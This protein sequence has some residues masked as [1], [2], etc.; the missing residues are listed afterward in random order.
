[1]TDVQL[2]LADKLRAAPCVIAAGVVAALHVGK[3]PPALPVL[4]QMLGISLLQASFLLSLVQ[5]AGMTLGLLTG[6][7]VQ[8]LGLTRS[9]TAG[10]LLLGCAS[11]LGGLADSAAWFAGALNGVALRIIPFFTKLAGRWQSGYVFTYA[12]AMVLGIAAL[13]TWMTLTVGH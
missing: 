13:L 12:F 3:L 2:S 1:M 5:L 10:L 7:A 6:L 11:A 9:M 8:R 4:E